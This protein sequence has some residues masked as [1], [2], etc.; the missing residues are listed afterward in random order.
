M[1]KQQWSW[2][3]VF[4]RG[5]TSTYNHF[6]VLANPDALPLHDLDV[7]K[8][9]KNLMLDLERG[10][11]GELGPL[12]N[13]EGLVLECELTPGLGEVDAYGITAGTLHSQGEDDAHSRVRGVGKVGTAT[14]AE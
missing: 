3:R 9:A 5:K 10:N 1:S 2:L 7:V 13:L 8:A 14:E 4:G 11:H 6:R 12:L